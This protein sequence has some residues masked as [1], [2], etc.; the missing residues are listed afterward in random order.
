MNRAHAVRFATLGLVSVVLFVIIEG[1]LRTD[2]SIQRM[3]GVVFGMLGLTIGAGHAVYW[4][5]RPSQVPD[6]RKL[7]IT[8]GLMG[9][10]G[11][12]TILL[13]IAEYNA[14]MLLTAVVTI[15][16]WRLGRRYLRQWRLSLSQEP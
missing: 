16:L 7:G 10:S 11:G 12:I 15:V 1:F 14:V 5:M 3:V 2:R 8:W 9:F 13:G 4:W 6:A